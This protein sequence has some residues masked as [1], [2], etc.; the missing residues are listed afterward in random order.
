MNLFDETQAAEV[1]YRPAD[2]GNQAFQ[3]AGAEGFLWVV[4]SC[5]G[6]GVTGG[7]GILA[8]AETIWS[9]ILSRMK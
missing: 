3:K 8:K 4:F 9:H 6:Y 5:A 7:T 2:I 1:F